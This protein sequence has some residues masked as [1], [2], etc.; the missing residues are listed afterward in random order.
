MKTIGSFAKSTRMSSSP[1]DV[2]EFSTRRAHAA[3]QG[4]P[5]PRFLALLVQVPLSLLLV[6]IATASSPGT[7]LADPLGDLRAVYVD[8]GNPAATD[9]DN[10][11]DNPARPFKTIQAALATARATILAG[12]GAKVIIGAGIYREALSI[13]FPDGGSETSPPLVI[14]GV[15]TGDVIVSGSDEFRDWNSLGNAIY[16]HDWPKKWGYA[17]NP[18]PNINIGRLALRAEMVFING[19]LLTQVDS[20]DDLRARAGTFFVDESSGHLLMH[21]ATPSL[22]QDDS[23]E[24]GIRSR[25]LRV[26]GNN[27]TIRHIRF[28]HA[29]SRIRDAAVILIG[30]NV[31]IDN[32]QFEYN[33]AIG[34]YLRSVGATVTHSK[35]NKNGFHGVVSQDTSAT[36]FE[37]IDLSENNWRGALGKFYTWDPGNKQTGNSQQIWR[38]IRACG[39]Q[40][41]GLWFDAGSSN[42]TIENSLFCSNGVEG[43]SIEANPGPFTVKNNVICFNNEL[44]KRVRGPIAAAWIGGLAIRETKDVTVVNNILVGNNATQVQIHR[45]DDRQMTT[46]IVLKDNIIATTNEGSRLIEVPFPI[47]GRDFRFGRNIYLSAYDNPQFWLALGRD[48][49]DEKAVSFA[50]WKEVTDL[51]ETSIWQTLNF[52]PVERHCLGLHRAAW[53]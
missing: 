24:V 11:G 17:A 13:A 6:A 53:R 10:S 33:N 36:L 5:L 27:V 7:A 9:K 28:E 22:A 40:S 46:N 37:D 51:D 49:S 39:N 12:S 45:Y 15:S 25:L 29:V 8:G 35:F 1:R 31:T 19:E 16:Q 47:S 4:V 43:L 21:L 3:P 48:Y 50:E 23:V 34:M 44:I 42:I 38:R 52:Q 30:E 26:A 41:S 20:A 18:W 32:C 2:A 14:E